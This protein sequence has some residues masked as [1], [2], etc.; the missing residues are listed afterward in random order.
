M[1][2]VNVCYSD[3]NTNKIEKVEM[4]LFNNVSFEASIKDYE[5]KIITL[6]MKDKISSNV[7]LDGEIDFESLN[8]LLKSLSAIKRQLE[9]M[10]A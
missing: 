4:S 8:S 2:K 10:E 7:E 3:F 5:N 6:S 9:R 1:S